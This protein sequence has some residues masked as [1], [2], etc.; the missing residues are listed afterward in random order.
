MEYRLLG[1]TG[2]KISRLSF[3]AMS[4]G[5]EADEATSRQLFERCLDAGIN[6]FDTADVYTSGTS[7]E[8]L[9]RLIAAAGCRDRVV[10]ASKAYFPTGKDVNARGS[11]RY[12]LV[13]AVEA[14]LRRLGTDRLDLYYLHR[15]DDVTS[16]EETLRALDDLVRQGKILYPAASNFAAWQVE[17]ALGVAARLSLAPLVA[18]QPMYNLTKRQVEVEILPMAAAEKLAAICY[19]PTG[20]GL[21]TGKYGAGRRPGAGRLVENK[22]YGTRYADEAYYAVAD[23]FVAMARE[24]GVH[25]VALAIAWVASHPA[26][27]SVLLGARTLEQLEPGLGALDVAMDAAQ[28]DAISSLTPAPPPATDRNEEQSQ[29]SFGAR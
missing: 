1:S 27:T 19:G 9:G 29:H 7:E 11:S 8:M 13:R 12:H 4:F 3:G 24:R 16:L 26:V 15:F 6:H 2:V 14:S 21:L 22:M 28:R 5:S 23:R 25:P 20:G 10:L 18:V 17:K